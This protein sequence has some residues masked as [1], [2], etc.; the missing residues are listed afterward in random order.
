MPR[1]TNC[2]DAANLHIF[3]QQKSFQ[4]TEL[5]HGHIPATSSKF[6]VSA[7]ERKFD[8]LGP[9]LYRLGW[10]QLGPFGPNLVLKMAQL[11]P[12]LKSI[13]AQ[14]WKHGWPSTKFS[15]QTRHLVFATFFGVNEVSNRA[16]S[17]IL[18]F[19]WYFGPSDNSRT[20]S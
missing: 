11:R 17:S 9:N 18:R 16:I 5:T 19:L 13:R 14:H 20:K 15:K 2:G 12:K 10:L 7:L 3:A 1:A 4:P 6:T 8:Q